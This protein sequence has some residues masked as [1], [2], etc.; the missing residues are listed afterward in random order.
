MLPAISKEMHLLLKGNSEIGKR[1]D[2][3]CQVSK[4][5]ST[6][7]CLSTD[8]AKKAVLTEMCENS[9]SFKFSRNHADNLN[10]TSGRGEGL[11]KQRCCQQGCWYHLS[12]AVGT[13]K[14]YWKSSLSSSVPAV[15][16]K[17]QQKAVSCHG[18]EV[19]PLATL[20]VSPFP[21]HTQF[22]CFI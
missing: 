16:G 19:G 15:L 11:A 10:D 6:P 17:V 8:G 22:I 4:A 9:V 20:S 14:Q 5:K 1:P 13:Q 18:L 7:R 21:F 2:L 12:M 3:G